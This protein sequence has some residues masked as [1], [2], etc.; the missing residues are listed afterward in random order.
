MPSFEELAHVWHM[1][2]THIME[3]FDPSSYYQPG[4]IRKQQLYD[5]FFVT[6][7]AVAP[8]VFEDLAVN[9]YPAFQKGVENAEVSSYWI[10]D[11]HHNATHHHLRWSI[12]DTLGSSLA[13]WAN[14]WNLPQHVWLL[15]FALTTLDFWYCD[16]AAKDKLSVVTLLPL[17]TP[18]LPPHLR[19]FTP[20]SQSQANPKKEFQAWAKARENFLTS[21]QGKGETG[22]RFESMETGKDKL[23]SHLEWMALL[24]CKGLPINLIAKQAHRSRKTVEYGLRSSCE[25]L[26]LDYD[27]LPKGKTGR[28]RKP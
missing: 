16:V 6:V 17:S 7:R 23:E 18:M 12:S 20:K 22:P 25:A 19:T 8:E 1:F 14:R 5:Q 9:V 2:G 27:S 28:P 3:T 15:E 13:A 4:F 21:G 11:Q 10:S 26:A 24:L